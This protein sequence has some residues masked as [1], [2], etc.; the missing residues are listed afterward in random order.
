MAYWLIKTSPDVFSWDMLVERGKTRWDGV[1]NYQARNYMREM[2]PGDLTFIYHTGDEPGVFGI[3][4]IS[5]EAYDDPT[6]EE[7]NW[8]VIDVE[9]VTK[10]E[11]MVSQDE[12]R[13]TPIVNV[14]QIFNQ[15][16][17]SVMPVTEAQWE[18]VL[19]IGKTT[20]TAQTAK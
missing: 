3:A 18:L 1:R 5:S 2:K 12:L 6:T 20:L 19:R 15:P 14:L 4:K 11:R 7:G 17:L 9:P 13:Y 8:S 10:I 16:K